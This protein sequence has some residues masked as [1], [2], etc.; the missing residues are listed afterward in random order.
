MTWYLDA[1]FAVHPDFKG[2]TGAVMTMGKGAIQSSSTKQKVKCRS[3]TETEV[4]AIDDIIS[5]VLWTKLFLE[6]QGHKIN[7]ISS[8]MVIKAL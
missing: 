1:A 2:H 3:S 4:V 8:Y 7:Q 5:K 6:N